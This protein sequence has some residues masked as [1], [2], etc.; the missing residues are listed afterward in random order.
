MLNSANW[1]TCERFPSIRDLQS[2]PAPD[3]R[4]KEKVLIRIRLRKNDTDPSD[5]DP[6]PPHWSETTGMLNVPVLVYFLIGDPDPGSESRIRIQ[7][8]GK[9]RSFPEKNAKLKCPKE[10][11]NSIFC[12]IFTE[13]QVIARQQSLDSI[14][15]I[16]SGYNIEDLQDCQLLVNNAVLMDTLIFHIKNE[17]CSFQHFWS[18]MKKKYREGILGEIKAE[19]ENSNGLLT[20]NLMNLEKTLDSLNNED[21]RREVEKSAA[22]DLINNEKITPVFLKLAKCNN[23]EAR[24]SDICD[25]NGRRFIDAESRNR[26]IVDY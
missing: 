12:R 17:V 20:D 5:P 1:F 4:S 6:D 22:F 7:I 24:L 19:K 16:L 23:S 10:N 11:Y 13:A 3:L 25:N 14:T 15:R 8:Q 18:K 26:F 9:K 21:L 2:D